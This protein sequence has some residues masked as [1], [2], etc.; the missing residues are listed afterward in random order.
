MP[1]L[2]RHELLLPDIVATVLLGPNTRCRD[3]MARLR[4]G[5]SR[6][7]TR[8]GVG[9]WVVAPTESPT[10]RANGQDAA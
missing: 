9:I 2:A 3:G 7:R 8:L 4:Q 6:R 10:A 1:I 5:H